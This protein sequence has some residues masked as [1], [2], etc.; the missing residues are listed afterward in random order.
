M[1]ASMAAPGQ[2]LGVDEAG[3]CVGRARML[4]WAGADQTFGHHVAQLS[5]GQQLTGHCHFLLVASIFRLGDA[6][7]PRGL[8]VL[9]KG[10]PLIGAR[11]APQ[12]LERLGVLAAHC[13]VPE[14]APFSAPSSA[15][16]RNLSMC[17]P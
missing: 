9:G 4:R 3:G 15:L 5:E 16:P 13:S 8:E 14:S 7:Q 6:A 12:L 2:K 10:F 11:D 17:P 1:A